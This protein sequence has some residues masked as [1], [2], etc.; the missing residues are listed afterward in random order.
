M[1]TNT[2]F[3]TYNQRVKAAV[4]K[5]ALIKNLTKG[6]SLRFTYKGDKEYRL[7]VYNSWDGLDKDYSVT[8][9][10]VPSSMNVH[11]ITNTTIHLYTYDMMSTRT[12]Y[13]MDM[14]DI[15]ITEMVSG[16]YKT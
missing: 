14:A 16:D 1:D 15:D 9:L 2:L 4:S 12:T 7:E 10:S 3:T 6:G 5:I 8:C 11:K 13:K